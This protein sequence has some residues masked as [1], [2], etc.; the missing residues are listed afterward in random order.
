MGNHEQPDRGS[1]RRWY[2]RNIGYASSAQANNA[3][4]VTDDLSLVSVEPS[5]CGTI[6]TRDQYYVRRPANDAS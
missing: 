5:A 1:Q 6:V 3:F 4:G 2:E